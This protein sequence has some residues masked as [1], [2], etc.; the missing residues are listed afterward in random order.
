LTPLPRS[1]PGIMAFSMEM[2]LV[3]ESLDVWCS[4]IAPRCFGIR[5]HFPYLNDLHN[6][7]KSCLNFFRFH[8]FS[9]DFSRRTV[10]PFV[11]TPGPGRCV[12]SVVSTPTPAIDQWHQA[13][14]T[15]GFLPCQETRNVTSLPRPAVVRP[16]SPTPRPRDRR[17]PPFH[18]GGLSGDT[19]GHPSPHARRRIISS[20]Y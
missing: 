4:R 5:V 19:N 9:Q 6:R 8:H 20:T 3:L 11:R 16:G 12:S 15:P 2:S 13:G 1:T 7:R 18:S 17:S 14:A 10:P